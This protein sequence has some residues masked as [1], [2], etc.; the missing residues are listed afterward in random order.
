MGVDTEI[1][2]KIKTSNPFEARAK[3]QYLKDLSKIDT[4]VLEKLS[5]LSKNPKAIKQIKENFAMIESFLG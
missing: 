3:M 4:D 5:K 1:Q 2:L